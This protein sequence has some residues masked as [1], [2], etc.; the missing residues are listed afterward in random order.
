MGA[1]FSF[2]TAMSGLR[3]GAGSGFGAGGRTSGFGGSGFTSGFGGS[4]VPEEL[5]DALIA[6]GARELTIVNNNGHWAAVKRA[7]LQVYPDG[8][9]SKMPMPPM[10]G[11]GASPLLEKYVEAS[12]GYGA[13][14]ET[15]AD[16]V[17]AIRRALDV[18]HRHRDL[19][20]RGER[21]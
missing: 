10:A 2:S 8:H 9:S 4:G 19:Q 11:L 7:T 13:R 6:Q 1:A 14:V 20:E 15:P 5:I 12:G 18:G 16:I 21:E 3:G 17:P